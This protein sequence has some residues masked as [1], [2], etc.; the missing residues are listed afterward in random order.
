MEYDLININ[1]APMVGSVFLLVFLLANSCLDK[2]IKRIFYLLIFF[3]I[4]EMLAFSGELVCSFESSLNRSRIF[5]TALGYTVRPVLL[6]LILKIAFRNHD[7]NKIYINIFLVMLGLNT[8]VSFSAFFTDIAY[9]YSVNNEFIRGPL[10]FVPH[11]VIMIYQIFL[12]VFTV[13]NCRKGSKFECLIILTIIAFV[14]L[15]MFAEGMSSDI[16]IGRAVVVLSIIF[17][18]MYFQS[19]FYRDNMSEEAKLRHSLEHENRMDGLTGLLNKKYF[20][21]EGKLLIESEKFNNI[22][23]IFMD[24]DYFKEVNDYLGH[25]VG[26]EVL[27]KVAEILKNIFRKGDL[28]AR[29]GGD[30]FC[31]LLKDIPDKVLEKQLEEILLAL[32]LSYT[33]GKH[34]VNISVS[35]GVVSCLKNDSTIKYESLLKEAD[36]ALYEAKKNGRN[37]YVKREL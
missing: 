5:W 10:G 15:S 2:K 17:Y 4:L 24:L 22:V 6:F 28:V 23:F 33:D 29:F 21:R 16:R 26:D 7:R 27:I 20:E 13:K 25:A 31:V 36:E 18:Y 11:I 30:E 3:Q 9:S 8:I 14:F 19:E 12:I 37:Q 32:Q 34:T 35:I 1:F